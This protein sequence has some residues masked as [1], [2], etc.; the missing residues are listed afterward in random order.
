[1]YHQIINFWFEETK[2]EQWWEKDKAFDALLVERFSELHTRAS[3]CELFEWRKHPEGRLAE[4]IVL[5]QFSRNIFRDTPLAFVTDPMSLTLS[6]EAISCGAD[7]A[8]TPLQRSFLYMPFMHSESLQIHEVAVELYRNN[9][10]Q[11]NLDFELSHKK[12]IEKFGRYPHRNNI[13]GR[14]STAE[15]IEFLSQPG[16][17]F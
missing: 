11:S 3:R 7:Q 10:I 4:I 14:Q 1:M 2:P 5:D 8:L 17:S 12:I 9:G 15:E 13:F 6:Q 16:S